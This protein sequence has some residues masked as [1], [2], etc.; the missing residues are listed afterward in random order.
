[1]A[2]KLP[3]IV[4]GIKKKLVLPE[5]IELSTAPLSTERLQT[6]RDALA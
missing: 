3:K 5:E 6:P 4:N 1:M 2:R